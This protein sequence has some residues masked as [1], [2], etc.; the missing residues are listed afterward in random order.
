MK[1]WQFDALFVVGVGGAVVLLVAALIGVDV[2]IGAPGVGVIT[3]I[4]GYILSQRSGIVK[5][6]E[7]KH[8]AKDGGDDS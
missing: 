6:P 3:L 1:P 4:L 7:K 5:D 8:K 2:P